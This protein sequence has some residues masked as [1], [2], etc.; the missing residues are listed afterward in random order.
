MMKESLGL[1]SDSLAKSSDSFAIYRGFSAKL[2]KYAAREF[3]LLMLTKRVQD[4]F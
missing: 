4:K 2:I 3:S 1:Y